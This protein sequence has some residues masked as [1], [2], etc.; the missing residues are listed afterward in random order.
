MLWDVV[1][2]VRWAVAQGYADSTRL[3]IYG[4]SFGGYQAL[5]AAAFAPDVFR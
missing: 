1:D 5:C 3:A 2:G 4:G